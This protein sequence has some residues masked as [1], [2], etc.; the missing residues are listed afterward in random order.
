ML[1]ATKHAYQVTQFL[2]VNS[3][4]LAF[5]NLLIQNLSA[6]SALSGALSLALLICLQSFEAVNLHLQVQ[7][8]LLFLLL[9]QHVLLLLNLSIPA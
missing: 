7:C 6:D 2:L 1:N 9:L 5:H 4:P 8:P 3:L